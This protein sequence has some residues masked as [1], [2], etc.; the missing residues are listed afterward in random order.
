MPGGWNSLVVR[1]TTARRISV[2]DSAG[3]SDLTQA[4]PAG[5]T[6]AW[7]TNSTGRVE[8]YCRLAHI[9]SVR[10]VRVLKKALEEGIA[11]GNVHCSKCKDCVVTDKTP[12]PH[13]AWE[14]ALRA[15]KWQGHTPKSMLLDIM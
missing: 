6:V 4:L 12:L 3:G 5:P 14:Y 1:R 10:A 15:A 11:W 8:D 2:F 7:V 9:S 13:V